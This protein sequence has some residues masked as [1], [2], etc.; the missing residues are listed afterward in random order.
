MIPLLI[1]SQWTHAVGFGEPHRVNP[2][3]GV[4]HETENTPQE[5]S[6]NQSDWQIR[7]EKPDSAPHRGRNHFKNSRTYRPGITDVRP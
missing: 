7:H 5:Q 6:A 1:R 3:Q 4:D 2:H